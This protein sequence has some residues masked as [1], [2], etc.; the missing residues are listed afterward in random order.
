MMLIWYGQIFDKVAVLYEGRQI[1]FGPVHQAKEYFIEL[2]YPLPRST[3][4]CGLPD[5]PYNAR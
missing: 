5:I 4:H 2:G 1:Y 3:N